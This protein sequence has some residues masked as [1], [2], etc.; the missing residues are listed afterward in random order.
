MKNKKKGLHQKVEDLLI[1][2]SDTDGEEVLKLKEKS[3]TNTKES[4][5]GK[6]GKRTIT[7]ILTPQMERLW[8]KRNRRL[9]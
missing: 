2:D 3:K 4:K 5:S 8:K 9:N 7:P 6:K 1:T